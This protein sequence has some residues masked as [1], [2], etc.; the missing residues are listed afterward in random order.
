MRPVLSRLLTTVKGSRAGHR[1]F[2]PSLLGVLTLAGC[3]SPV[4]EI[5]ACT[6]ACSS[7]AECPPGFA[8]TAGY[9]TTPGVSGDCSVPPT[10]DTGLNLPARPESDEPDG[11]S[12]DEPPVMVAP[13]DADGEPAA[14]NGGPPVDGGLVPEPS[15]A[16]SA[17][18]GVAIAPCELPPPCRDLPYTVRFTPTHDELVWTA[19]TLPSGLAL[20]AATLTL[21][22]VARASGSLVLEG[23]DARGAVL[24]RATFELVARTSCSVAFMVDEGGG[25]RLHLADREGLAS[26]PEV[27]LPLAPAE[28]ERVVDFAFSPDGRALLVRVAGADGER[29]LTLHSAPDWRE[30]ALPALGGSVQEYAWSQD[31]A[32][33]AAVLQSEAGVLLG[34]FRWQSRI[35]ENGMS[36][37]STAFIPVPTPGDTRP[38][39]FAGAHVGFLSGEGLVDGDRLLHSASLGERG[40][41]APIPK[42]AGALFSVD[43]DTLIRLETSA[44]GLLLYGAFR[45]SSTLVELYRPSSEGVDSVSQLSGAVPSSDRRYSARAQEGVLSLQRS[46]EEPLQPFAT[47]VASLPGCNALLAWSPTDDRLACVSDGAEGGNLRVYELRDAVLSPSRPVEGSYVY[48][49][50]QARLRPRAFSPSGRWLLFGNDLELYTA[51]LGGPRLLQLGRVTNIDA[52]LFPELAFSPNDRYLTRHQGDRLFL[53]LLGEDRPQIPLTDRLLPS[54]PCDEH[55]ARSGQSF[56]GSSTSSSSRVSWASDSRSILFLNVSGELQLVRVS[57]LRDEPSLQLERVA[58]RPGCADGCLGPFALQP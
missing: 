5:D 43:P 9:C 36:L 24:Q 41:A 28:G 6:V 22:G 42:P 19:T 14:V 40:F 15:D 13:N 20:D 34:G 27:I 44:Q 58:L 53:G 17:A 55:L 52:S 26:A 39:W 47:V 33:V 8:C 10:R 56:C 57:R 4:I 49:E 18:T 35:A 11:G 21:S 7:D 3:F 31:G 23:R 45:E 48:S 30:H 25:S 51:D 2:L 54:L 16:C 37:E 1:A 12:D 38:V 50:T 29:R 46:Y 32:A